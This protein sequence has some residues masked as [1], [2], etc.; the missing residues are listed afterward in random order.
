MKTKLRCRSGNGA[1][2]RSEQT[3]RLQYAEVRSQNLARLG[4]VSW[5][6]YV[7]LGRFGRQSPAKEVRG[8]SESIWDFST[9]SSRESTVNGDWS[10][11]LEAKEMARLL[12]RVIIKRRERSRYCCTCQRRSGLCHLPVHRQCRCSIR[13]A[14]PFWRAKIEAGGELLARALS[15]PSN[16]AY[17][18]PPSNLTGTWSWGPLYSRSGRARST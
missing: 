13:R 9:S 4:G 14:K 10:S 1:S 12:S 2:R 16:Y 18:R 11:Q 15:S 5:I 17:L 3:E 6:E 7:G 8:T